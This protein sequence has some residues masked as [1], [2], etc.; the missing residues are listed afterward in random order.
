MCPHITMEITKRVVRSGEW[1]AIR[2]QVFD[3]GKVLNTAEV[4][5]LCNGRYVKCIPQTCWHNRYWFSVRVGPGV[6][7]FQTQGFKIYREF[8][9][10]TIKGPF[11]IKRE[12]IVKSKALKVICLPRAVSDF[13]M[14]PGEVHVENWRLFKLNDAMR[15]KDRIIR[16]IR[17]RYP[18]TEGIYLVGGVVKR[19]WSRRDLDIVVLSKTLRKE[20]GEQARA[21]EKEVER[22]LNYPVSVFTRMIEGEKFVKIYSGD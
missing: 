3:G 19:G 16:F 14:L 5:L 4:W 10:P 11:R 7:T 15:Y 21:F 9:I 1:F 2:G 17:D 8:L 22:V 18:D 6:Y 13:R 20:E 12:Y